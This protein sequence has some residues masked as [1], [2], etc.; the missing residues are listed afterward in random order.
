[1]DPVT[2][3]RT[4]STSDWVND[5]LARGDVPIKPEFLADKTIRPAATAAPMFTEQGPGHGAAATASMGV[6]DS[7]PT[8]P[9]LPSTVL[10]QTVDDTLFS[11]DIELQLDPT[12][13]KVRQLCRHVEA[14]LES[15][16]PLRLV[17]NSV[18]ICEATGGLASLPDGACVE[19]KRV[20]DGTRG[21]KKRPT[22]GKAVEGDSKRAKAPSMRQQKMETRKELN[23]ANRNQR[24]LICVMLATRNT[25]PYGDKCKYSHDATAYLASKPPDI[26]GRL[27]R[28]YFAITL[29]RYRLH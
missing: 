20:S 26:D 27:R 29:P 4:S 7:S 5:A 1:M 21:K 8:A 13:T 11:E 9:S 10:L 16:D 18:V 14:T 22:D 28:G 17:Y 6:N 12:F 24:D 19:V 23:K 3:A 2:T 25:C 15:E